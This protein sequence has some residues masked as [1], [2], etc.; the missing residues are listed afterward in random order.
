MFGSEIGGFLEG[1]LGVLSHKKLMELKN[2]GVVAPEKFEHLA[3]KM[4]DDL[5]HIVSSSI[6]GLRHNFFTHFFYT[7]QFSDKEARLMFPTRS[8][9][10][11]H[12]LYMSGN[13]KFIKV[14]K[15]TLDRFMMLH[16]A[17]VS[18][19]R[20]KSVLICFKSCDQVIVNEE[21]GQ[22][23]DWILRNSHILKR[24]IANSAE[25]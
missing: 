24:L 9:L 5:L 2:C 19:E 14:D 10:A 23:V 6:F 22:S 12:L 18:S 25:D 17:A 16:M 20:A 4:Y 15:A 8:E 3:N 21:V 11:S 7:K 13:S 1:M